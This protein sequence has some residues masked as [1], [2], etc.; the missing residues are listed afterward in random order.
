MNIIRVF[1][2]VLLTS[3]V[4]LMIACGKPEGDNVARIPEVE[5]LLSEMTLEEKIGQMTQVTLEVLTQGDSIYSSYEP[6]KLNEDSVRKAIVKYHVGSVLNTA[7]KRARTVQK[8]QEVVNGIQRIATEETRMKI[9]VIYGI[10]AIYGATYSAGATMFPQ[11]IAQAASWN[12]DLVKDA[13]RIT[14]YE[15]R[16]SSI[17]W[18]FSPSLDLGNDPRSTRCWETY[19][20]DPYLCA[21][22]GQAAINGYQGE[23]VSDDSSVATCLKHFLGYSAAASGKNRTPAQ[24]SDQELREYHLPP[25]KAAIEAGA[26]SVMI[27]SGTINGVPAHANYELITDLLKNELEFAGVVVTGWYDIENLYS[28]DKVAANHKEAIKMAVNAGIDMS[29]VPYN[30]MRFCQYLRELVDEGEVPA[31][32]INDAARRILNLKHKI[33]L[34]DAYQNNHYDY[35]KFGSAEFEEKAYDLASESITLLKNANSILPLKKG[36]EILVAGPNAHSMRALNGG[37]TNSWQGEKPEEFAGRYNTILQAVQNEFGRENVIYTPGVEYEMDGHYLEEENIRIEK[38][39]ASAMQS[40]VVLLCLGENP[41][42][43]KPGDLNDLTISKNQER[44]ALALAETGKPVVLVLNEGRPRI[45]SAFADEVDAII[46]TYLPGN[47]GGDALADILSGEVNP[48]GKLPYKYPMFHDSLV[49]NNDTSSVEC[50]TEEGIYDYSSGFHSQFE[51][52]YGLSYTTF[53]YSGL[54]I[55][56]S[57]LTRNDSI[58]VSVNV[59]NIGSK[60]GKEVVQLYSAD[61]YASVTQDVKRLC[62]FKKIDLKPGEERE[63]TFSLTADD[64]AFV[65]RAGKSVTEPGKFRIHVNDLNATISFIE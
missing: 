2:S 49:G 46:Q 3:S 17:A 13:A 39:V 40:D 30:Y 45:I 58:Q 9:P 22:M 60:R 15:V 7:N 1:K 61:R 26:S 10:D 65:N 34:L 36:V 12:P 42:T 6:L 27:N 35:P 50:K 37:W 59:R 24:I 32:R 53:E 5:K 33:G 47:S 51:F 16:A 21:V 52:G 8:W 56:S 41:Y 64:L 18:N 11:Q 54:S 48:S 62:R 55:S 31:S 25:F 28:S 43:E 20:E 44:L 4:V 23:D 19:G 63:V 14:A 38:A 57:E 29:M